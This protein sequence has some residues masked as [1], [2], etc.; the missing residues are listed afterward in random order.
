MKML[1]GD[2]LISSSSSNNNNSNNSREAG[3]HPTCLSL[4]LCLSRRNITAPDRPFDCSL[5][6]SFHSVRQLSL[7]PPRRR[8]CP[9]RRPASHR[10]AVR[11]ESVGPEPRC[12]SPPIELLD[13][14]SIL[15]CLVLLPC[16]STRRWF[17]PS[18]LVES[19]TPPTELHRPGRPPSLSATSSTT[20]LYCSVLL[21]L[22]VR[23]IPS[24]RAFLSFQ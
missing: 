9:S 13:V 2:V 7:R 15:L 12:R 16:D 8:S 19:R 4:R 21:L 3:V 11:G 17:F 23:V 18:R 14:R 10:R 5:P 22:F 1:N 24:A 20:S 6:L